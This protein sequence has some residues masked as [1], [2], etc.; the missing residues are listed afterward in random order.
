MY[1]SWYNW[2]HAPVSL[3][4]NHSLIQTIKH[5]LFTSPIQF[6]NNLIKLKKM[7]YQ[8]HKIIP[9]EVQLINTHSFTFVNTYFILMYYDYVLSEIIRYVS[10][11]AGVISMEIQYKTHAPIIDRIW[12]FYELR[13]LVQ[14]NNVTYFFL[15]NVALDGLRDPYMIDCNL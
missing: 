15:I 1:L 11:I 9:A 10:L 7:I 8:S 13:E 2:N 6:V 5:S 14:E 3:N 12:F 4:N